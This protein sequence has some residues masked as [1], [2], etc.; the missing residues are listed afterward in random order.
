VKC[1]IRY[2]HAFGGIDPSTGEYCDRNLI[3]KG[4]YS[5]KSKEKLSGRPLPR[6][7][8]PRRL[9]QTPFDHPAPVG[10]GFYN[11]AWQPRAAHAGTFDE[12]WRAERSPMMPSDFDYRYYNGAHP[13]LQ[14]EGYLRGDEPVELIHLTPEG[15]MQFDLPGV[16]PLCRAYHKGEPKAQ[17][18]PMNLD[19]VFIEPDNR[20]FS[21]VWRGRAP[22]SEMSDNE[23][24][25]VKIAVTQANSLT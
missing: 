6:I 25:Q 18:I 11:R 8:D 13:D 14:A 21:L 19:T 9:I 15:C 1:P 22:L 17:K 3:G 24:D 23:I 5:A 7:E 16:R 4:F 2:S 10:F 20:T 12:S